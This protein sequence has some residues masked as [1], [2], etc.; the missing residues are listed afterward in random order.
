MLR[1]RPAARRPIRGGLRARHIDIFKG[2]PGLPAIGSQRAITRAE[3]NYLV[4]LDTRG[5]WTAWSRTSA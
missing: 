3:G 5:P 2:H 1:R 4:T